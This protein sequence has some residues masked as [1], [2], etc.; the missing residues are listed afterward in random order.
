[1][2]VVAGEEGDGWGGIRLGIVHLAGVAA[3]LLSTADMLPHHSDVNIT[4][5]LLIKNDCI[6]AK[7]KRKDFFIPRL[8]VPP[9]NIIFKGSI[10]QTKKGLDKMIIIVTFCGV[11][12]Q[13]TDK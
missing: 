11:R 3:Y 10:K 4:C 12:W 7:I 2:E 9:E 6:L 8:K 13:K 1:M 5:A